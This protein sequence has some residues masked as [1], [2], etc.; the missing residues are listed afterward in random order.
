MDDPHA[1]GWRRG[2]APEGVRA[3][4]GGPA[5][6]LA[7]MLPIA[8][9]SAA[10]MTSRKPVNVAAAPTEN[11]CHAS[12]AMPVPAIVAPIRLWRLRRS[13]S[14]HAARPIV[15]NTCNWMTSDDSPAG[16]PSFMPMNSR[17][18]WTTPIAKP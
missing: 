15:K 11:L 5:A 9:D 16:M 6:R 8:H 3:P 1:C 13:C 7:M 4:W 2:A 14:H 12:T 18:N 17:P 10:P